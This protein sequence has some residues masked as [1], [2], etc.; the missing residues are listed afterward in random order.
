MGQVRFFE[1]STPIEVY[2][3]KLSTVDRPAI[4]MVTS[5]NNTV[6]ASI[7][8]QDYPVSTVESTL[9][10]QKQGSQI[11]NINVPPINFRPPVIQ[12]NAFYQ[13]PAPLQ[14]LPLRSQP[15]TLA[16]GPISF[17]PL[18]FVLQDNFETSQYINVTNSV[19]KQMAPSTIPFNQTPN[20]IIFPFSQ[21]LASA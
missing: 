5:Q 20:R 21:I 11:R 16:N 17:Q 18:R 2:T 8:R 14:T 6:S 13:N 9:S 15:S 1:Q 12:N 4:Q 7:K 19:H 10:L 3:P